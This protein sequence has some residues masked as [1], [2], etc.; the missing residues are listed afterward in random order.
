MSSHLIKPL[1]IGE[2]RST[3]PSQSFFSRARRVVDYYPYYRRLLY[4]LPFAVFRRITRR[5]CRGYPIIEPF[6]INKLGLEIGG[7]SPM[8]RESKLIP[9]YDRCSRIDS[10]NFS[11]QTIWSGSNDGQ[12]FGARLVKQYVAEACDLSM[13]RDGTY[14]FVLASHVLEHIANPLRALQEWTRILIPGG[15]LLVIVPDK[16]GG[17][18]HR[19]PFTPFDHI[20]QDFEANTGEDDLTHLTEILALHDLRLDPPAGT[21]QQFRERCLR[22]SSIRAMHHHVFSHE[23]LARM[24]A[25]LNMRVLTIALERPNHIVGFVQKAHP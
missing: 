22:N 4:S 16:R 14:D 13:V 1:S 11:S 6:L 10:C 17:F 5:K 25:R 21:P 19:R 7:P 8:F 3:A 20:E 23:V 15:V 12:K 9:V 24:F 2:N 18:D